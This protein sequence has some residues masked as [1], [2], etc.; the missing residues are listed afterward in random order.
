MVILVNNTI[1]HQGKKNRAWKRTW[2]HAKLYNGTARDNNDIPY[3]QRTLPV[4]LFASDFP[5]PGSNKS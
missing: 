4:F 2:H 1:I 5:N 3:P